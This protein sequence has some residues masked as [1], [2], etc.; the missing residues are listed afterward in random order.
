MSDDNTVPD[1]PDVEVHT[2]TADDGDT[3]I[4]FRFEA[5]PER[6]GTIKWTAKWEGGEISR[7]TDELS[8]EH[9]A[10]MYQHA[11]RINGEKTSGSRLNA[12][13]FE[14]LRNDLSEMKE[15]VQACQE[16]KRQ[17]KLATELTFTVEQI[18]YKV[19]TFRTE[20]TQTARVLMPN[21]SERFWTDEEED[22][23]EALKRN[24]GEADGNPLAE[25]DSEDESNPFE[26]VEEGAQFSL[27][28]VG[29]LVGNLDDV[30]QTIVDERE[31]EEAISELRDEHP[32]LYGVQFDPETV[33]EAFSEASETGEPVTVTTEVGDCDGSVAECS[34]DRVSYQAT[35]DGSI[36]VARTHTY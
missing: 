14:S 34:L 13:L 8:E 36:E 25:P 24:L 19:G 4:Q 2:K 26:S 7:Y 28:E 30:L 5:V 6:S 20:Y 31:R 3:E 16:A 17:Q 10:I 27:T 12:D 33:Q 21:K 18:S 22:V 1:C 32:E 9:G 23:V 11:P 29:D 15:F 35:P